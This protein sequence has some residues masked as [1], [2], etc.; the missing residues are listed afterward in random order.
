MK[1]MSKNVE[2]EIHGRYL[3]DKEKCYNMIDTEIAKR[4]QTDDISLCNRPENLEKWWNDS[5]DIFDEWNKFQ[6]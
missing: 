3:A 5:F 1:I 2:S 6:D 4:G